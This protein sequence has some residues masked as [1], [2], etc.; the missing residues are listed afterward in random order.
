MAANPEPAIVECYSGHTYAQE[1]RAFTWRGERRVVS[2][3]RRAWLAPDGPRFVVAAG[4]GERFE[5]A[6]HPAED[7]W[8]A[9]PLDR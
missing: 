7:R 8:S 1:P 9:M 3:I 5:L 2:E 4:A 6:Y